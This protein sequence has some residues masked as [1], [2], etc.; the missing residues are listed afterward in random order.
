M[1]LVLQGIVS[2]AE[3]NRAVVTLVSVAGERVVVQLASGERIS[4]K[5][6]HV[7]DIEV[8]AGAG[9]ATAELPSRDESSGESTD[10]SDAAPP[11]SSGSQVAQ[12]A[13]SASAPAACAALAL[14]PQQ[15]LKTWSAETP[16]VLTEQ[17]TRKAK[18]GREKKNMYRSCTVT[19]VGGR[20]YGLTIT[21]DAKGAQEQCEDAALKLGI[22]VGDAGG[23]EAAAAKHLTAEQRRRLDTLLKIRARTASSHAGEASNATRLLEKQLQ[24]SGM[25]QYR[26]L[27]ED[28]INAA[29][30]TKYS[31][32]AWDAGSS[33]NKVQVTFIGEAKKTEFF[34]RLLR[35][36]GKAQ[37]CYCFSSKRRWAS[38]M[39]VD[40]GFSGRLSA[41]L[42]AA[43]LCITTADLAYCHAAQFGNSRRQERLSG[44]LAGI[45]ADFRH[46]EA[47]LQARGEADAMAK[48]WF[49]V[50][51]GRGGPVKRRGAAFDDARAAGES[52]RGK[53]RRMKEIGV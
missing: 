23:V 6:E 41:A 7:K 32:S 34:V 46:D 51:A 9:A 52:Q 53:V 1:V 27:L 36:V 17:G 47:A 38:V 10:T 30:A 11:L 20:L 39:Y 4:V 8:H 12:L 3:L 14:A 40:L 2:R 25:E 15:M 26:Q 21:S 50:K 18:A 43:M 28:S 22:A 35:F 13:G 31:G 29:R 5:A 45:D 49:G 16:I 48:R 37:C 33:C 19:D 42:D 24:Q 44:F